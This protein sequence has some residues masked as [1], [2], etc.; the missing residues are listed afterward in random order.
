MVEF[1][2]VVLLSIA[3]QPSIN[4][5]NAESPEY[6]QDG[7][8]LLVESILNFS[9]MLLQNCG[10]R[11][12]YASSAHLNSILNT[13]S[14]SLLESALSLG[15]ELAQ[16]YQAA[17]KR[18]N[19]PVRHVSSAL[20]AN[21]YNIDLDRVLQLAMPFSKTI[22]TS[23]ESL[24]PTTPAT[25]TAKGKE[26]AY[27]SSPAPAQKTTTT[28]IYANDLVSMV[29]G[30]SGVNSSPKGG[31]NTVDY[32][33]S[34]ATE[35]SW[36][37]WGD[38]KVTYY[39]KPSVEADSSSATP[40]APLTPSNSTMPITPTPV[41]RSSNLGPHAQRLPGSSR[42][43]SLDES[44]PLPR[45]STFPSDGSSRPNH[46]T[47][48]VSAAELKSSG[49]HAL[50]REHLSGLPQ[51]RHYELLTKLRVAEALTTSVET[52]QQILAIRL[53]AITNLAFIHSE[54]TF[55]EEV[56]K[57]DGD[58]P[59]RVQL[60]Y[61]LAELVH[62]PAE[63]VTPV[64]RPLQTLAFAALDALSTHQV[65]YQD[66]C[67][68]LNTNVNH[69]VLL[70]VV[71]KAVAE[72][73]Q[74]DNSDK[75]TEDDC[76]RDAL[77][78]LLSILS[79]N[80]RTAAELV[81]AGLIPILV[82]VLGLHTNIA[83]RY[84]PQILQFLDTILYAARDAFQ[85]LVSA[86]GLDAVSDL[87]VFEVK[88]ASEKALSGKGILPVYRS[89]SVDYE[90]PF[91]QQQTLKWLFKFI[92][93][94]MST[95]G[96]YGGNFDRLLRNLIDS[97]ALLNSLRQIIG[98]S[99]CFGSIVWTNAVSIL[100]DFIN[101]EPTSFAVIAE[102]GLSRGLLEAV[103]GA[104]IKMPSEPKK[105]ESK[106][107]TSP[108]NE[109]DSTAEAS[110]PP[111]DDD[112]SEDIADDES[113]QVQPLS[114]AQLQAPRQGSL[115]RGIM[116]TS[117]TINI[118]PQAF[119]AI[120]LNTA[121]MKMFQASKALESFF[122]IFESPEHVKCMESNKDLPSNLGSSFD[123][124]VRH[125]PPLKAAIMTSVLNMVARVNYLCSTKGEKDKVG[126]KLWTTDS[127]GKAVV[128]DGD[129]KLSLV[130]R[131]VKGKGKIVETGHDI[132]MTDVEPVP[133][134]AS[135]A[136]PD[137]SQVAINGSMTPYIA[138][139]ATFLSA[140]FGNSSAR[141]DFSGK[142]GIEYVLDLASS[143]CLSYDFSDGNARR[144]IHQVIALLAESKPHLVIPSLL[145]R[146]QKA[147]NDLQPFANH[148]TGDS[149]FEPFVK[150]EAHK[151]ADV[152]FIAQGTKF[153]KG[154]VNIHSM[155]GT[156]N[157]CFQ[158]AQIYA[159]R[160]TSSNF[161]QINVADYYIALVKILG[162]L[163]GASLR[164]D[165]RLQNIV[166]DYW[167]NATRVKDTGF[168]EPVADSVLGVE[169]P[170][171]TTEEPEVASTAATPNGQI[172]TIGTSNAL[173]ASLAKPKAP[174][175]VEQ[176]SPC[177]K[178]YQ[179]LRYLLSKLPRTI[180]PFFQT[181]GKALVP[182]RNSDAFQ[183]YTHIAIADSLAETILDQLL[184][185]G[186]G[187]K[188]DNYSYWV[189]MLHV[190]NDMLIEGASR[191]NER[192]VQTI[193]LVLQAFK[194]RGGIDT[195]NHIL[196]TFTSE[197]RAVTLPINENSDRSTD[198]FMR[199]ELATAGTKNI[200]ALYAQFVNGK[201][202]T[203]ASQTLA[204]VGSRSDRERSRSDQLSAPQFLV[205]LRM[206]VLPTVRELWG[207]DIV[208]KG[209]S[210]IS[211]KLIDVIRTIC[212]AD[213]ETNA[214][215]RSDK[216]VAPVK[217]S[218]KQFKPT[219]EYLH[220]IEG[221]GYDTELS[222]EALYRCNNNVAFAVEYCRELTRAGTH[223]YPI[224]AGDV[225]TVQEAPVSSSRPHTSASTGTA[226]PD[227]HIMQES[228]LSGIVEGLNDLAAP[229]SEA[230]S[231]PPDLGRLIAEF[232]SRNQRSDA[233][234]TEQSSTA[235][236]PAEGGELPHKQITIEDLNEER[237]A[238]R[239]NLIDRCLDVI[240]AHGEVTFEISDLITTVIGKSPD[241]GSTRNSVGE[242]LVVAL[243]SFAGEDDLRTCGKKIAA[244]AHLL[245]LMLR[246]RHFYAA[247]L[248]NLKDNLST[249]LSFVKLSPNH[250]AEEPS[251]WIAHILLI[252]EM[253]LS[254]DA[255]PVKTKWTP[256]KDDNDKVEPLVFEA[257]ELSVSE[258][259][260]SQL[261]EAILD[262]LPRIGKDE[263]LA[264]AV[265]RILV[266][267]TRT[268]HVAQTMGEKKNIQRLF[269]MAKQL[270]GAS[271]ARIQ[272]P[273]MLIL[274]HIIEDDETI[275]QIM[276]AEI[277][278][279]F[280]NN[281]QSR[282]I[283][284]KHFLR[285]M[286]HTALRNPQLFVHVA[287]EMVKLSRWSYPSGDSAPRSGILMLKENTP[288]V[289]TKTSD[290]SVQPAVQATED[291]SIQD[292][293]PSTE[294]IDSEMPDAPKSALQEQKLPVVENP[295]GVIHFL[296][297]ELLNYK[298]VE[299]KDPATATGSATDKPTMS[300]NGDVTMSGIS[301]APD[302]APSKSAKPPTKP[303]FKAEDHPIYIYR[304]FILQCL[305]ELLSSYNR[306]KIEFINFKRSAPPQAMTPSKP[307]SSVVNYLLFDLI[308][309]GTLDHTESTSLRKK[310][311]T[312]S[313]ADSV[314]TALLSKTGEHPIDKE[315][316]PYDSENEPDLLFV[317]RFVLENI[318][319][320]YREATLSNEPLDLKYS[321]LLALADLMTHIMSGK[322][323]AGMSDTSTAS[324]SQKQLRRLM[325]EKGFVSALTSSI[326]DIDLDFPNAKRA[327]KYILRPLKTLTTTAVSLSDL[328]LI[329][330]TPG[331]N[332]D[333]EIE[334]ATSISD[335][336]DEREETPDL[337]R[338][339]TLGMFE[340]GRE[341][342]SSSESDDGNDSDSDL[343]YFNLLI[344]IDDDEE[345]YEAG[346]EDEM[347]YEE[348]GPEDDED[349]I[350]DEDEE[351]EGMGP[352][353]GLSGE[354]GVDVEVIM[355]DD[356]E[357]DDDEGSSGDDDDD[358]DDEHDSEDDDARVEIID[359]AG[360]IQQLDD[361]EDI[362][363][364][365]ESDDEGED[366]EDEE[367]EDYEGQAA[368]Q[369]EEQI[370]AMEAIGGPL[371][372]LVRALG[373][374]E[375]TADMIE[376]MEAEGMRE[377]VLDDEERIAGEFAEEGDEEGMAPT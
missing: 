207:S 103:T 372:N 144:T 292:V 164:E 68:A 324:T 139:V 182:K 128:A 213:C 346:Y 289:T 205:E 57:Q 367:E 35:S 250:S 191:A 293:K 125:H 222:T 7:D 220:T 108:S 15:S 377:E 328:A 345:M 56:L 71:R 351:I 227:D 180:S 281:R 308:P 335:P 95:A 234:T 129:V 361:D 27:F 131:S 104:P 178:N 256:P 138:A 368:D 23:T 248:P 69:G 157:I 53:L 312:A 276:R 112:E 172:S 266:T 301:P 130:D 11:S 61:Q 67:S 319:K 159:H 365:W 55:H 283:D 158:T 123:E 14:L 237:D 119:G 102:A 359:E 113:Y 194:D 4:G 121:G 120:C 176:D 202:V 30:G 17:L 48:E 175:K 85:T 105:T 49:T 94:M 272:S 323:N 246:D 238:I 1:G 302:A 333:E 280:E 3:T 226:T 204:I 249:L 219:Q 22:T 77:F 65:K 39:P 153:V 149:F 152:E 291:L 162:P 9:R 181:L 89:A 177:F 354:H 356:D 350:S 110:S 25:P 160:S 18:M 341:E 91:F 184:L 340:P 373:G 58:E 62:P 80:P 186:N 210:Q 322:E 369:E 363:G 298:D 357:E 228:A 117:E 362:M 261:L 344:F 364:E 208:E 230:T 193:T 99:R 332:D 285:G 101:N 231:G 170:T 114:A 111:S 50:L 87:I 355:E 24:Q 192:P 273:L 218:R 233:A 294:A 258:D 242:T 252:I 313:W 136:Q 353:E 244:Y 44:P 349:N 54:A 88:S 134:A 166:P 183:K 19:I 6:P 229:P 358:D 21:H 109:P 257:P 96:G 132:D 260:R 115:A 36:A 76:W 314:L 168:G 196:Q 126:A 295:D 235:Q 223:R 271:S 330:A 215:K 46:K 151:S 348:G 232:A 339:S 247:A 150:P 133:L 225:A 316:E 200:L 98:N 40:K 147:A 16:R 188:I 70:Y 174:T 259:D 161:T 156:I 343:F 195:L 32:G 296:L 307:R 274:R 201:N 209:S 12:I 214:I 278:A 10:N 255:R 265:L 306:T 375:A 288:Q 118:V 29:K 240:N 75:N 137:L 198:D 93:H 145:R 347:E 287:S 286:A 325:F 146:A 282:S 284:D 267:L 216:T 236:V 59:R 34:S 337:F 155:V 374:D 275:K 366:A 173:A 327:V 83:E 331:Q 268:R 42:Q 224:P 81:T 315:R 243:M 187:S 116:P 90:I 140:M 51:D 206:A 2:C 73:N 245:A 190:L 64:P 28:T 326:A 86:N 334:S 66:I 38:V 199:F 82:E 303:E 92:H 45:I 60:V 179:T 84:H 143:P 135:T 106:P 352:I 304:C 203:E 310:S 371:G 43:T 165:M 107:A 262:I 277:K 311:V 300:S 13:T 221:S 41:R 8:R 317:R 26:K 33:T 320:A 171:P 47:V 279:F 52:R 297:C 78:S 189:G 197:I 254:E 338:N 154:L 290:D 253:L 270:A 217:P 263:S 329:S 163:L 100:N 269:V 211:E 336:E 239:E 97:S 122:E 370:Q 305:T 37:D 148:T 251:P 299:D 321:R 360:N 142:G 212:N 264:L 185:G 79:V 241:P 318:L 5:H 342:D 124:L 141:S 74:E 376:R 63:G 31:R 169:P 20:L 72:M 127:N 167:K 309:V